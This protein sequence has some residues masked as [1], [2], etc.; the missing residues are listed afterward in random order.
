MIR[1]FIENKELDVLQDFS[2]QI[3][4]SIDDIANIDT[5]TTSFSK[6]IVLPGTA[7]N[8]Q[9]LGNIFEFSNSNFTNDSGANVGYNFNASKS[10]KVRVES[11][12]L[13]IMKGVLRLLEIVI[14]GRNIEYE[15]GLFGELGGFVSALGTKRLEDLDFSIYDHF[16]NE[17]FWEQSWQ[18]GKNWNI[19]VTMNSNNF[20]VPKKTFTELYENDLII[21][22]NSGHYNNG[23]YIVDHIVNGVYGT[24][25]Y[26]KGTFTLGTDTFNIQFPR[27]L[28]S[29]YY[30]PLIDYGKVSV[31]KHDYQYTALRPALFVRDYIKKII[32]NSGYTYQCDFFDTDVFRRLV[33]PNNDKQ[34]VNKNQASYVE[35]SLTND[36]VNTFPGFPYQKVNLLF[37][38]STLNLFTYASGTGIYTYNE[39][40]ARNVKLSGTLKYDGATSNQQVLFQIFKN[41]SVVYT[42]EF[43]R[44]TD[45]TFNYSVNVYIDTRDK[46]EFAIVGPVADGSSYIKVYKTGSSF[47]IKNAASE[48]QVIDYNGIVIMNDSLPSNIFQKDFFISIMKMFNL[49]VVEDRYIPKHLKIIPYTLFYDL[50]NSSYL[51]WTGKVDRSEPIRIKPMSEINSRY[52]ELKYK[53]DSDYYNDKYKKKY[54]QGYGDVKFDNNLE[55][56]KDT[57]SSE[58]IFA[59][60][61][62][63]GY[64]DEDKIIPIIF[65]WDG[66]YNIGGEQQNED[67][68]ASVLRIMQIK[69]VTGVT[70]WDVKNDSSVIES[71]TSYPYAGHLDDPDL[72][73]A[74]INF[75][76]LN[77]LYFALASGALGNNLFNAFYSP[78]LAEI[79]DKDSRMVTCK[80]KFTETDIFNLDFS[81]FIWIDQVLYRLN[82]IYDYTP[83][84]LCKVDLLRVIYTTYEDLAFQQ[85]PASVQIGTQRWTSEN[86][87]QTSFL[88]G[89]LISLANNSTEWNNYVDN[90]TPCYAF[91]N[92]D[93]NNFS[94]G[95]FYNIPA[96]IDSRALGYYGWRM[97]TIDDF[98]TL[99]LFTIDAYP[100]ERAWTLKSTTSWTSA[101]GTDR[102]GFNAKGFGY[103]NSD[104]YNGNGS[105]ATFGLSDFNFQEESIYLGTDKYQYGLSIETGEDW[106]HNG[107]NIRLIKI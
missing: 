45:I 85:Q 26:I 60:T 66:T 104:G 38:N 56:V 84:E 75:G 99:R 70:S 46:L 49:M 74:D 21:I 93:S 44:A 82:K 18:Q 12:G 101:N 61:P 78:Y 64:E 53:G 68:T 24:T 33:I 34:F 95:L 58:V 50:D 91:R 19:S 1:I 43:E 59:S 4:Y 92:F 89:D 72:P 54:N 55:F 102:Y 83:N 29:G 42:Y 94:Q 65:K 30:Y 10:A 16:Y 69:N 103:L 40:A 23:T 17:N 13:Q 9:L 20:L 81:K 88:N 15:V 39:A 5:K 96:L 47:N 97:P 35:A 48:A 73:N 36:Y 2:H 105:I 106:S 77:E 31:N 25:I 63:V 7:N 41:G 57:Q 28:S 76:A 80:M 86:L 62:L 107:Y 22:T 100:S 90:N 3:T 6:T 14:D 87:K 79:T 37:T 11:N 51:D 32:A 8:N 98:D 67:N 71:Y 52:Y 27:Y